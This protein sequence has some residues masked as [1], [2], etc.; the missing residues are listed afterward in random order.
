MPSLRRPSPTVARRSDDPYKPERGAVQSGSA[1]AAGCGLGWRVVVADDC[2]GCASDVARRGRDR[3]PQLLHDV[4]SRLLGCHWSRLLRERHLTG[5]WQ[6]RWGVLR[7][8]SRQPCASIRHSPWPALLADRTPRRA[9][10]LGR[11]DDSRCLGDDRLV[12][13]RLDE[14]VDHVERVGVERRGADHLGG[15]TDIRFRLR[16]R[17]PSRSFAHVAGRPAAPSTPGRQPPE[18]CSTSRRRAARKRPPIALS[19]LRPCPSGISASA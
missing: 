7:A 12:L 11:H 6:G 2:V 13:Q 19:H 3:G 4:T 10:L 16:C 18:S 5:L 14:P 17:M 15:S 1:G 9:S 8:A